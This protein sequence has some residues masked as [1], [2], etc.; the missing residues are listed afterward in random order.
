VSDDDPKAE[1]A[2]LKEQNRLQ[3]ANDIQAAGIEKVR[4]RSVL[5][6]L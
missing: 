4:I 6:C 2:R 1:P 5:S 3:T